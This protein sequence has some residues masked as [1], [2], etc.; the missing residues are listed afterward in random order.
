MTEIITQLIAEYGYIA[1]FGL[2]VLETVFPPIPSELIMPFAGYASAQG[3]MRLDASIAIAAAGSL[4]GA[5]GLYAI[6]RLVS[7]EVI[8]HWFTKAGK[9]FGYS[10]KDLIK[11]EDWFDNHRRRTV[12]FGRVIPGVRSVVSLPAGYRR[13]PLPMFLAATAL[14]TFI[15]SAALTITG[16]V[17]TDNYERVSG[18]ISTGGKLV[19]VIILLAIGLSA[20]V[21]I[22][23]KKTPPNV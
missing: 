15:W 22:K 3:L 14:G 10:E 13:M 1:L 8:H 17:L 19:V 5:T 9:R 16:Y 12:F 23:R 21:H 4:I 11:A 7:R 20:G 18:F 6:G 2:T